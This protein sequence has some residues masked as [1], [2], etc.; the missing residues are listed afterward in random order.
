M[1]LRFQKRVKLFPGVHLNLSRS[2]VSATLGV[3]GA[4]VTVGKAGVFA[5]VGLPG[6]G[7]SYRERILSFPKKAAERETQPMVLEHTTE[8]HDR[9]EEFPQDEG[10]AVALPP[11]PP[12]AA[13]WHDIMSS[14]L[15]SLTSE[16]MRDFHRLIYEASLHRRALKETAAL[17]RQQAK[18]ADQALAEGEKWW[19][20][21]VSQRSLPRLR[22]EKE[23]A[24]QAVIVAEQ[25]LAHCIIDLNLGVDAHAFR[26]YVDV[27]QFF[28]EMRVAERIWDLTSVK[29]D[30]HSGI[31]NRARAK[32]RQKAQ[33]R[34]QDSGQLDDRTAERQEVD[35][36]FVDSDLLI[37]RIRAMRLSNANGG[38][39]HIYPSFIMIRGEGEA[40][41]L[42]DPR[43]VRIAYQPIRFSESGEVPGDAKLLDDPKAAASP[44]PV[45]LY[46]SL[47][48]TSTSGLNE[49]WLISN[50]SVAERFAQAWLR[51]LGNLPS[52]VKD[53][54]HSLPWEQQIG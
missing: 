49:R 22:Q 54:A 42:I 29:V 44:L 31:L 41:A 27:A 40:F 14:P 23:D 11:L 4:S 3:E 2:G 46:G 45:V 52:L 17:A 19:K 32:S 39:V 15:S 35:F 12:H 26:A 18:I 30:P 50:A 8:G 1:G 9:A 7:I 16:A 51:Y 28:D 10:S 36:S 13:D 20:R 48:L 5:N 43:D 37:C 25:N 47:H 53:P 33:Q 21:L 6:S 38:D 24:D 34:A